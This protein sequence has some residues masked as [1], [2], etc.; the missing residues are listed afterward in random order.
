M[1]RA[2]AFEEEAELLSQEAE[3]QSSREPS[4]RLRQ[5]RQV[6]VSHRIRFSSR[7]A[8]GCRNWLAASMNAGRFPHV[9]RKMKSCC[10]LWFGNI[11]L[12]IF[13]QKIQY[14][15][16]FCWT[17]I[18]WGE[19]W[20]GGLNNLSAHPCYH[21]STCW[22]STVLQPLVVAAQA[23]DVFVDVPRRRCPASGT[24]WWARRR[25]YSRPA[26]KLISWRGR[27]RRR[28]AG[29]PQ[30]RSALRFDRSGPAVHQVTSAPAAF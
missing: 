21:V 17:T 27:R 8:R 10:F 25:S 3:L 11:F 7:G 1:W 24:N 16:L 26:P 2:E 12:R 15:S 13:L 4:A 30:S 9:F 5:M 22:S 19:G 28:A 14:L 20:G 29:G 6:L 23:C 18:L